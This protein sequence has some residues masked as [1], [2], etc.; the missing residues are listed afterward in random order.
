MNPYSNMG[1]P[2][3][4]PVRPIQTPQNS[5]MNI[6]PQ[7]Q[8]QQPLPQPVQYNGLRVGMLP[9]LMKSEPLWSI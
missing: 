7:M 4:T 6:S 5:Y 1:Y 9:A 3:N 8:Y 2:I